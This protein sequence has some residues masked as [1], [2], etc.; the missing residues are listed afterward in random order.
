MNFWP[1]LRRRKFGAAAPTGLGR[2]IRIR[3]ASPL[4][5]RVTYVG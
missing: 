4:L 3:N 2:R 1:S 5:R